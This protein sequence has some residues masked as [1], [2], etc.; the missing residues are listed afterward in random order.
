MPATTPAIRRPR[1]SASARR[2]WLTGYLFVLPAALIIAVFGI[3]PIGY[4]IYMSLHRW[5][6]RKGAFVGL[7]NYLSVVGDWWGA[8]AFFGD[9][10]STR[11]NSSHVK[12]SYAV[13]C[14]NKK[15]S[16]D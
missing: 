14:L 8:L 13:F 5:R 3:F 9:R 2:E 7:D 4:A 12:N 1:V 6:I 11:L 15:I 10:K 16:D